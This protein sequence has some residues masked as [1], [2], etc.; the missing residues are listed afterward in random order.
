MLFKNK[1]RPNNF[2]DLVF[3]SR[4][5]EQVLKEYAEGKRRYPLIIHGPHGSGKSTAADM[6]RSTLALS[7]GHGKVSKPISSRMKVDLKQWN[8]LTL[9][10]TQHTLPRGYLQIDDA[11]ALSSN[12]IEE[13]DEITETPRFGTVIITVKDLHIMP[14]WLQSRSEKIQLL[15]PNA[16]QFGPRAYAILRAEGLIVTQNDV[17]NLLAGFNGNWW[18]LLRLLESLLIET[19]P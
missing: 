14:A 2:N 1:H 4:Q 6:I 3:A 12:L 15:F 9:A 5:S 16:Q 13:L 18:E 7:N 8:D 19:K 10:L 17:S 11:D